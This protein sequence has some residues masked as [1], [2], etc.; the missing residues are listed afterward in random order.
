MVRIVVAGTAVRATAQTR[1]TISF[2][3]LAFFTVGQT[4]NPQLWHGWPGQTQ[5]LAPAAAAVQSWPYP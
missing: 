2:A 3:A 1:T 5:F 4:L